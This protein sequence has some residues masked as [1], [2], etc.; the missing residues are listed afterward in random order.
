MLVGIRCFKAVPIT[1]AATP[2]KEDAMPDAPSGQQHGVHHQL[3]GHRILR[4]GI[5][6]VS[7][8]GTRRCAITLLL[9]VEFCRRRLGGL[10]SMANLY[11]VKKN[12]ESGQRFKTLSYFHM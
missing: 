7:D 2:G 3:E 4:S 5:S 11:R 6:V 1:D 9:R 8:H 12:P 10:G